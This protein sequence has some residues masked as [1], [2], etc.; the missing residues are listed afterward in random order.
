M[1]R[2]PKLLPLLAVCS[3]LCMTAPCIAA[4]TSG[5]VFLR[6]VV[7]DKA[8]ITLGDLFPN[9]GDKAGMVVAA[10]PAPGQKTVYDVTALNQIAHS[11]DLEWKPQSTYERVVVSQ[12]SQS[13]TP[14]MIKELVAA[15]LVKKAPSKDMD[16]VL[17]NQSLEVFRAKNEAL[18][19][20]LT[21]LKYD[22]LKSRFETNLVVD[23]AGSTDADVVKVTGRAI[24]TVQ[25]AMLTHSVAPGDI[26]SERDIEWTRVPVDKAGVDAVTQGSRIANSESRRSLN[27]GAVLRM[28]DLRGARLVTKGTLI[29]ISVETAN[30]TLNAQGRAM[31][32]GALGD[33]VQVINTQSNRAIDAVVVGSGKVSVTPHELSAKMAA[34]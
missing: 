1:T 22:P 31:S 5:E 17:D 25:V 23:K 9:V 33:T 28:Q 19:Y 32:D 6:E 18:S 24:L 4:A 12:A 29:T 15:E 34:K 3:V 7:L 13:V 14:S 30:M 20:H 8:N 2:T 11:N 26:I 27:A 21:E 10:V 16:V